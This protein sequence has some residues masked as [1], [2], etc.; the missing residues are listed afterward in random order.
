MKALNTRIITYTIAIVVLI[1]LG[2]SCK[3]LTH[4]QK[5]AAI[6]AGAGG[7]IGAIIGKA[8]GNTALGAIIGGAVGGTA[9]AFIG[10]KMD[11]QAAQIKQTVP[12]A[13]VTRAGEGI[14]VKF[15]SGILFDVDKA[16]LKPDALSNLQSLAKSMQDNPETNISIIG[17]TDSTG[18]AEHN[19]E[20]SMRRA[21]AVKTYLITSGVAD[22]RLTATGKGDTESIASNTTPEGRAKNRRVEIIITA[23]Q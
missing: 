6:G 11:K 20:L 12:G 15:D 1:A 10:K 8:A 13:T 18:T 19:M 9:G 14:I 2:M 4:T 17:H 21:G 3:S 7:T 22:A 23:N 16:D 5:G